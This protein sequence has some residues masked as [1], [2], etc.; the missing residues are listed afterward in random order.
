[1]C[2]YEDYIWS[3]P[4]EPHVLDVNTAA[5]AGTVTMGIGYA[6]LEEFCAAVNI[7]RMSEKTYINRRESLVDDFQKT[8]MES[9]KMAGE[10]E[11]QLAIERN[12]I[13]NGIPYITV[14]ADGSWM[15][16]SYGSAYDSS[17]GVGA[18]IG[19][20][21]RKVHRY[22]KQILLAMRHGGRTRCPGTKA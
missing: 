10:V 19:Y 1:M 16:R 6:Q 17:S 15:K 14:V 5:V 11:K 22:P 3:E 7:P 2:N 18:I 12:D 4:T 13:I 20:Y 9:M 8:A 21:T